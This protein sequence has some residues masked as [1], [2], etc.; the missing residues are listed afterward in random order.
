M[1]NSIYAQ[2]IDDNLAAAVAK[3][4]EEAVRA[5]ARF[6]SDLEFYAQEAVNIFPYGTSNPSY[7][8]N[9]TSARAKLDELT[10]GSDVRALDEFARDIRLARIAFVREALDVRDRL[11]KSARAD[12]EHE[13]NCEAL[14][15]A[16]FE[17]FD[18]AA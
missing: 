5:V 7:D 18:E 8:G 1:N 16:L 12:L 11:T 4:I 9:I 14:S 10:S 15:D 13:E 3:A 17:D 6:S 2:N